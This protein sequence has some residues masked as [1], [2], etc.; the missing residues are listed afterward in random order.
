M[1]KYLYKRM[2]VGKIFRCAG[3]RGGRLAPPKP[4]P[5]PA[6]HPYKRQEK[7]GNLGNKSGNLGKGPQKRIL[8]SALPYLIN[9]LSIASADG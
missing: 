6:N 1:Q 2:L 7:S 3:N 4:P 9:P 5:P 8:D